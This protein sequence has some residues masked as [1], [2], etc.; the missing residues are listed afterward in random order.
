M[1]RWLLAGKRLD[2]PTDI[3]YHV[4][5]GPETVSLADLL[6]ICG[7]RWQIEEGFAQAKREVGLDQYEVRTWPA[8]I[9]RTTGVKET[10]SP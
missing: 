4:A 3:G 10:F 2:D 5:Y 7:A 8:S 6:H 9:G 1:R